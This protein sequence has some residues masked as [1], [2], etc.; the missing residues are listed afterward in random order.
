[1][2]TKTIQIGKVDGDL[3]TVSLG[4]TETITDALRKAGLNITAT[5]RVIS[6]TADSIDTGELPSDGG[7]YYIAANEVLGDK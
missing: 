7:I 4:E 6:D 3:Q 1:M 5:Q 2:E